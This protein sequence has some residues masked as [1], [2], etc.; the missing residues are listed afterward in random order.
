MVL[1]GFGDG[2]SCGAAC[3][4]SDGYDSMPM[5]EWTVA[6]TEHELLHRRI[7]CSSAIVEWLSFE[8]EI[9]PWLYP[10]R[11]LASIDE[12]MIGHDRDAHSV[13]CPGLGAVRR[14]PVSFGLHLLGSSIR[15]G[16]NADEQSD[17]DEHHEG[18]I[19]TSLMGEDRLHHLVS[20][21]WAPHHDLS[22]QKWS[23]APCSLD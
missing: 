10:C 9:I 15:H 12:R 18:F 22:G 2:D 3:L 14:V 7:S 8:D 17:R 16:E 1:D 21:A 6:C 13:A 23:F 4:G 11:E 19:P 5:V 20:L